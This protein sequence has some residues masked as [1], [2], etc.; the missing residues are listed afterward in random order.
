LLC[1]EAPVLGDT[2]KWTVYI[3]SLIINRTVT[4]ISYYF[5]QQRTT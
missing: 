5:C 2:I 1:N 3:V 4:V